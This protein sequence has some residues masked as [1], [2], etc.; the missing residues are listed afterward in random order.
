MNRAGTFGEGE[1]LTSIRYFQPAPALADC[2]SSYYWFT[3]EAPVF[4][5]LMRAEL[6]QLRFVT[7]GHAANHYPGGGVISGEAALLQG[8]TSGPVRFVAQG[9]LHVFGMG[10]LP[11]G[12]ARL[13][14]EPA[15]RLAD[16]G[17]PLDAVFGPA[18]LDVLGALSLA[19][20]DAARIAA[21]DGFLLARLARARDAPVW[22]TRLTDHWLTDGPNPDVD[23]LVA[24]SGM[25]QRSVERLTRR[26]YGASPKL[27]ARKYR[28]L[29]AAVR[30]G[31]GEAQDWTDAAEGFY[32]QAHFIRDFRQ[33]TG[34]TPARFLKES[35]PVT[36]LTIARKQ[37]L[38]ALPRLALYS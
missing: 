15:D 1:V 27:M 23:R 34:L 6:P 8:P 33:F 9:P 13:I 22:F 35:A 37:L 14:G 26:I 3:C 25:S 7:A 2:V 16:T 19:R 17:V 4:A 38:P 18:V 12:W 24:E 31:N 10:L 32:D 28:A 11:L 5:D 30:M 21:V 20:T 36:R 29:G